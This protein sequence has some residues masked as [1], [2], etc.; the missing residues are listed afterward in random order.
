MKRY[1][2]YILLVL[3]VFLFSNLQTIEAAPYNGEN[4]SIS[5]NTSSVPSIFKS[6][7]REDVLN[8]TI[9]GNFTEIIDGE[10]KRKYQPATFTYEDEQGE[11]VKWDIEVRQRG[12]S[13]RR[14]CEFPPLKLRFS[15]EDL[16]TSGLS[17]FHT[18]KLVTHCQGDAAVANETLLREYLAYELFN[19]ITDY[20]YQVQLVQITYRDN[21]GS[22]K[23]LKRYGFI[24][25]NNHEMAARIDGKIN[26][27]LNVASQDRHSQVEAQTALF[28]Y[29]IGN[30]D[31]DMKFAR[32]IKYVKTSTSDDLLVIPYDFD[33]SGLVNASYAK[34]NP[35]FKLM[36]VRERIYLGNQAD[37]QSIKSA[38]VAFNAKKEAVMQRVN[39]FKKLNR[40]ARYDIIDYLDSFYQIANYDDIFGQPTLEV[41]DTPMPIDNG[42]DD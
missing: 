11:E 4:S 8:L 23:K 12:K 7:Q 30:Q 17:S 38:L 40:E 3:A 41:N 27:V 42:K 29:M 37:V 24:I 39:E 25:E 6:L 34:P 14:Y 33:F 10:G 5:E 31:W 2:S 1:T 21:S 15:K 22:F 20:S 26:D 28:Q 18:L 16:A 13:R 19:E 36:S 9:E 32:N 35:D